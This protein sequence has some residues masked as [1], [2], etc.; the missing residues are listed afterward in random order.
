MDKQPKPKNFLLSIIA[1]VFNE[2]AG[3]EEFRKR[4]LKVL[5]AEHYTFELIFVNDG[6][7]DGTSM[8]LAKMAYEDKRIKVLGFSRNFGHQVAVS[9]GFDYAKGDAVVVIDTDLQDPPE[10]IPQLVAKWQ[11]GFEIVNA[12][13]RSRKDGITKRLTAGLFYKLLNGMLSYKIPENV[14]DFRLID[15]KPLDI[16]KSMREKDRYIRGMTNWIGFKQGF[17]EFDRDKRFAGT[18][19]YP[20]RKMLSLA[21]NALFSFSTVPM[22]LAHWAFALFSLL[23]VLTVFYILVTKFTGADVPG[24]TS[25]MLITVVFGAIQMFVLAIISEYVGRIYQQGQERPLYIVSSAL[26]FSEKQT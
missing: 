24:W 13:R 6:S 26:N 3:I 16:L 18:T 12:M 19:H 25:Q 1:P 21:T 17:V 9:A 14:G 20:L 8:L 23:S 4:L 7:R 15:R 2:E 10:L 22:K 11:E 5:E